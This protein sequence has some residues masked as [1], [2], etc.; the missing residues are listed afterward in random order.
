MS[1]FALS[2]NT[3]RGLGVLFIATLDDSLEERFERCLGFFVC[4]VVTGI[5][6]DATAGLI[7]LGHRKI[8]LVVDLDACADG[9][10]EWRVVVI[11]EHGGRDLIVH[12]PSL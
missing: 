3:T 2:V 9:V 1:S 6:H 11:V 12:G 10:I 4:F 5:E 7:G 8:S